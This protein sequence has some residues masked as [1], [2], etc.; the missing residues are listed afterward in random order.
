MNFIALFLLTSWQLGPFERVDEANPIIAP[1]ADS[2]FYCPVQQKEIHW[3]AKHTFNPGAIVREGKV[4]LFYR[5][6]DDY[7][8]T[9]GNH[10]S[11]LARV[12][13][14]FLQ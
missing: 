3:E 10:T 4:Y 12:A 7:G 8:T 1:Y 5:A 14:K 2:I 11:R 9:L 13:H 6:E